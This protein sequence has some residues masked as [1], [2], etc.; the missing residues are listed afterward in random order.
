MFRKRVDVFFFFFFDEETDTTV[1]VSVDK[2]LIDNEQELEFITDDTIRKV[3]NSSEEEWYFSVVDIIQYLTGCE[4][5]RKYW[6]DLKR[7]LL[8][9]G[10][11]LS[12]K[13][14]QLK[15]PSKKDGKMYKT[16]CVN[17]EQLLRLIQSI[18][19][20]KVEPLKQWLA[21][22]GAEHLDEIADPELAMQRSISYYK[23]KGYSDAWISQRMRSIE[24]R[25]ELTDEWQRAGLSSGMDYAALTN[26]LTQA[27]SGKTVQQYKKYKG[28]HKENLRD[29]MTNT[30]LALNQLAEVAT[31][32][33]SRASNPTGYHE[34]KDATLQGG[35]I[36]GN[37]RKDLERRLGR[38][39]LSPLNSNSPSLLD[40][41]DKK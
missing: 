35:E 30:E 6:N 13:I 20:K 24:I 12:V 8:A 23:A 41:S 21:T 4:R 15:L 11:Q 32:E 37:A 19:S 9:E 25:K 2:D 16:D 14:G 5:P 29:N 3:W 38:S 28:L 26:I 1:P 34:A 39:V 33:L 22:V 17:T 10:S 27:W 36:A 7:Q 40:D 31:T 18:P